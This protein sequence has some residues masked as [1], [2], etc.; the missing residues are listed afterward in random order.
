MERWV[1]RSS[2]AKALTFRR[3]GGI[4]LA[5]LL[6]VMRGR[7]GWQA[8]DARAPIA[9]VGVRAGLV[10]AYP[11]CK[12]IRG[13]ISAGAVERCGEHNGGKFAQ[14]GGFIRRDFIQRE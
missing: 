5:Q 8:L 2:L 13:R 9:V 6:G 12:I 4:E 1:S 11:L 10:I 3:G 14:G 7:V